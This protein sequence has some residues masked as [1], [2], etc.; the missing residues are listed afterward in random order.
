[1][2]ENESRERARER[3]KGRGGICADTTP[4]GALC[5]CVK[6]CRSVW[7]RTIGNV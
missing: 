4:H 1:M 5:E 6:V 7:E 2:S 3:E